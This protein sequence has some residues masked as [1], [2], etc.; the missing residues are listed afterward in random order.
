M[1]AL[2]SSPNLWLMIGT[3]CMMLEIIGIS[4]IGIFF[5]GIAAYIIAVLSYT[6]VIPLDALVMQWGAWFVLSAM[7]GVLLW[8]PLRAMG[9]P[10]DAAT[11][12]Y[13]TTISGE[14]VVVEK[15]L[16]AG[17][18]GRATWSGTIMNAKLADHHHTTITKDSTA[19]IVGV[20]GNVLLLEPIHHPHH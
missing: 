15:D 3:G 14:A 8:K 16:V 10:D 20:Q 19:R 11:K 7:L 6:G 18:T 4:G 9:K 5:G 1:D 2:F 17:E 12:G 13:S